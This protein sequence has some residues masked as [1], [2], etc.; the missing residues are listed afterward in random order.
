[1]YSFTATAGTGGATDPFLALYVGVFNP[2][3][4]AANL[5]GCNDDTNGLLPAFSANLS[6]GTTY[7]VVTTTF[8]PGAIVG[9]VNF[10]VSPDITLITTGAA[11]VSVPALGAPGTIGLASLLM[12]AGYAAL[13]RRASGY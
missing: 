11:P 10:T 12:L 3:N 5:V 9:T 13:K 4:P 1:V 6:A 2:A 8:G 7:T